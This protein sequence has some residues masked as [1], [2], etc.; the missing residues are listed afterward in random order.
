MPE[1]IVTLGD[2]VVNKYVFEKD[3]VSIGRSRDNDVVIENLAVS[4]NHA[5]IRR[6]NG[7]FYISDL[8]S[9]NG[10]FVNGNQISRAELFHNDVVS[11]GKHK[12]IFKNEVLSDEALIS[13]AFGAER[14]MIVNKVP[15]AMLRVIRGKQKDQEFKV[16]KAETSIGRGKGC[17]ICLHD[18]F[19]GKEHAL[20]QRRGDTFLL[21]DVGSWRGTKVNDQSVTESVLKDGDEI[22]IGGTRFVFRLS[23]EDVGLGAPKQAPPEALRISSIRGWATETPPEKRRIEPIMVRDE[24]PIVAGSEN[25]FIESALREAPEVGPGE[26]KIDSKALFEELDAELEVKVPAPSAPKAVIADIPLPSGLSA[27]RPKEEPK[28][29]EQWPDDFASRKGW[30]AA[31]VTPVGTGR[32]A[33]AELLD[34]VRLWETALK[35]KSPIIRRQAA[36]TLKKMTGRD[37]DH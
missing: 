14:T 19:V 8:N 2:T 24:G 1:I 32:D 10:T 31:A 36:K 13:D 21:R 11:I 37:Y 5:R 4:R 12:M 34:E 3:I 29:R 30:D 23:E 28:P 27:G 15:L 26:V 9:A 33:S 6:E 16:D 18:W 20:I 7:R 22:Q 35:N 25:D 17:T